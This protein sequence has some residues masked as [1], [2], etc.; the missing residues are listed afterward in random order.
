MRTV[1]GLGWVT[2][3]G[4]ALGGC[5]VALAQT[6]ADPAAAPYATSV[7]VEDPQAVVVDP[8]ASVEALLATAAQAYEALDYEVCLANATAALARPD[9][10]DEQ[11]VRAYAV[12]AGSLAVMGRQM[13]A[14]RGYRLLV[15][16]APDFQQPEGTP[17][18]VLAAWRV[19]RAEED[20]I[21]RAI[22]DA[23]RQ[24]TLNAIVLEVDAPTQHRGG[25]P[26]TIM[27][28]LTDPY[29]G[30]QRLVLAYRMSAQAGFATVPFVAEEDAFVARFPSSQ[31][32][33][34]RGITLQYVVRAQDAA[35]G[36]LLTRGTEKQPREIHVSA[37]RPPAPP[38]YQQ[39][40]F[41]ALTAAV[42]LGGSLL[43]TAVFAAG[44][45]AASGGGALTYLVARGDGT[46]STPLGRQRFP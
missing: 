28:R 6:P 19:V 3:V 17:P 5:P 32:A 12:Q 20:Q 30:I 9:I 26:L 2:V 36:V 31:T 42:A 34:S 7:E 46:P 45:V 1:G 22:R 43:L 11:R 39:P 4:A 15:R 23:E 33:S 44:M 29:H 16:L 35:G 38:L 41:W 10:T 37:G 14:E 40:P 13:E 25:T 8:A 27:V 24:R 21:Q 18:K